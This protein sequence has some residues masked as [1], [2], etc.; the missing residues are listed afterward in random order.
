MET[1]TKASGNGLRTKKAEKAKSSSVVT[2]EFAVPKWVTVNVHLTSILNGMLMNPMG[3]EILD[4]LAGV[5]PKQASDKATPLVDRAAK[6]IIRN[7]DDEISLPSDYLIAALKEAGREEKLT[8]KKQISTAGTTTLFRFL[9]IDQEFIPFENQE[10][11]DR[12]VDPK[13]DKDKLGWNVDKRR[14]VL[15]NAGKEVAVAIIRPRF[16]KWEVKFNVKVNVAMI[17]LGVVKR[18]FQTAGF[19][20]VG[21]FRPSCNGPF[22]M[23]ELAGWEPLEE[24]N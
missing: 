1:L 5:A 13:K 22:G 2:S 15:N 14:G 18:L 7:E 4:E 17:D 24:K 21:D 10:E 16:R 3:D 23:F 11:M 20:G 8:A 6:K 9:R 19:I 12:L